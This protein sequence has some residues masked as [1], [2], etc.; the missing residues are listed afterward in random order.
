MVYRIRRIKLDNA[1]EICWRAK[2]CETYLTM[3]DL[4]IG[5][6][7]FLRS[8]RLYVVESKES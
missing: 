5:G 6:I 7:Y 8:G 3:Q 4:R 1:A 2:R